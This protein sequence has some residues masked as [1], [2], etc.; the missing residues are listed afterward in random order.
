MDFNFFESY[1]KVAPKS[2]FIMLAIIS[3]LSLGF[4]IGIIFTAMNYFSAKQYEQQVQELTSTMESQKYKD[5]L[6]EYKAKNVELA[7][8][9]IENDSFASVERDTNNFHT[10]SES[11]FSI[12]TNEFTENLYLNS[13]S[14]IGTGINIEGVGIDNK[15]IAN[16]ES[17]L[18][19]SKFFNRIF[20]N[21]SVLN[22]DFIIMESEINKRP[23]NFQMNADLNMQAVLSK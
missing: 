18:R 13:V 15:S 21:T 9:K 7:T 5:S 19:N 16:Y 22:E 6:E 8:V 14:I 1:K 10:G 2:N 4:G 17:N 23:F 12:L 11:V 20:I 3:I